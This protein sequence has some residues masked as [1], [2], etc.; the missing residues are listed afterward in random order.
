[1]RICF[2]VSE[3]IVDGRTKLFGI[4]GHPIE[5][6]RSPAAINPLLA[7]AGVNAL[8]VPFHVLPDQFDTTLAGL[9]KL[10]NLHGLVVTI[11]YKIR[12]RELVAR[13][14]PSGARIGAINALRRERDGTW[15][16]DNFDGKGFVRALPVAEDEFVKLKALLLGA[17]GAG[18]AIADAL[19]DFGIGALTVYDLD[20]SKA[21][22]LVNR[23]KS[24]YPAANVRYGTPDVQDSTL[25]INATPTGLRSDDGLPL[26]VTSLPEN[27]IVADIVPRVE[28][29]PLLQMAMHCGCVCV[30]GQ[31][32]IDGQAVELMN[33]LIG[34]DSAASVDPIED[35]PLSSPQA[36]SRRQVRS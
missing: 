4:I 32:M 31:A 14:L 21:I 2:E 12:A 24:N 22:T 11:P 13:V 29:T 5:Q 36:R 6:V 3:M 8:L 17:G 23:L 19:I 18:A 7:D 26:P 30:N 35:I 15:T 27:V 16:G 25:L 28:P 33:F 1:M 10:D 34:H 20:E 9:M